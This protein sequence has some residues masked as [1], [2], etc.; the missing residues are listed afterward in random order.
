MALWR[1]R[2]RD[3]HE[4]PRA[5][6]RTTRVLAVNRISTRRAR[7]TFGGNRAVAESYGRVRKTSRGKN[8]KP[9]KSFRPDVAWRW[10]TR[11]SGSSVTGFRCRT[12]Y[13]CHTLYTQVCSVVLRHS[14]T[15]SSSERTHDA[16]RCRNVM[17]GVCE[18]D[19]K[20]ESANFTTAA[21]ASCTHVFA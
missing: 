20:N 5:D 9:E 19:G 1:I 15:V 18:S 14:A 13:S 2:L 12:T 10:T 21:P 8:Q 4:C 7:L 16:S 6:W 11:R 3:D 17:H